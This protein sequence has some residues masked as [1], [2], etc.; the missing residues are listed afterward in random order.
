MRKYD[1]PRKKINDETRAS[2]LPC[3]AAHVRARVLAQARAV[4]R[5]HRLSYRHRHVADHPAWGTVRVARGSRGCPGNVEGGRQ[6]T[7]GK[8]RQLTVVHVSHAIGSTPTGHGGRDW[9]GTGAP[10][11]MQ[12]L[13]ELHEGRVIVRPRTCL[14]LV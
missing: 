5:R 2:K 10:G 11:A 4:S 8:V 12:W 3:A 7:N 9:L 13:H 14:G 1:A 6:R